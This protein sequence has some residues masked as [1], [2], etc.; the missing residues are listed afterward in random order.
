[1]RIGHFSDLHGKMQPLLDSTEIPDMWVCTGDIFPNKSRGIIPIEVPF[2][3]AWFHDKKESIIN[4]L[5]GK[6][7]LYVAGN[8]DYVDFATLLAEAGYPAQTVDSKGV[9]IDGVRFAGFREIPY[10]QGEWFGETHSSDLA[11]IIVNLFD[12]PPDVLLTHAPPSG[13]LDGEWRVGIPALT[14]VLT[15][16]PH[17]I[18]A[19]LFGHAHIPDGGHVEEMGIQFYNSACICQFLTV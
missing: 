2:Q 7:L 4:K 19:H 3:T 13:I 16:S 9:V 15:Y 5:G 6:P 1:M 12:N 11:A 14:T 17:N 8:H 10:I 18:R